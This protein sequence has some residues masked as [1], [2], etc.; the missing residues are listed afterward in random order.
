MDYQ[1]GET[2]WM[3]QEAVDMGLLG[4]ARSRKG[5]VIRISRRGLFDG[6]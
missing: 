5:R 3:T 4:K 1:V 6:R 2:L